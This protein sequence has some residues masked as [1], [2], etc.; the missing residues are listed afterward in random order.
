[1]PGLPGAK[2]RKV[3]DE[4]WLHLLAAVWA[5]WGR[6][7][8]PQISPTHREQFLQQDP[9]LVLRPPGRGGRRLSGFGGQVFSG[10]RYITL[11]RSDLSKLIYD[12]ISG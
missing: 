12:P 1:M 11:R 8:E 6:V 5:V 4:I 10:G 3:M 7:N 2:I 9:A